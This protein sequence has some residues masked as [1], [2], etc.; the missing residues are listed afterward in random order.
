MNRIRLTI[1]V[2]F[3][4]VSASLLIWSFTPLANARLGEGEDEGIDPDRP[5]GM[6]GPFDGGEYIK[7]REAFVALLRGVDPNKPFDPG[8]ANPGQRRDGRPDRRFDEGGG[9]IAWDG[10]TAGFAKLG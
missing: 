9:R 3:I 1:F 8:G 6:Q 5:A 4:S 7:Q 10:C 2:I